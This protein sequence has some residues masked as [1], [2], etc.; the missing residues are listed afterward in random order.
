MEASRK[1]RNT[2]LC[3]KKNLMW[4]YGHLMKLRSRETIYEMSVPSRRSSFSSYSTYN[5]S[6]LCLITPHSGALSEKLAFTVLK[7][8]TVQIQSS[9]LWYLVM[10]PRWVGLL[11]F[12]RNQHSTFRAKCHTEGP[13][14]NKMFIVIDCGPV[15]RSCFSD[16][17]V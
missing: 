11:I 15:G 4:C 13:V 10:R 12:W 2:F 1:R 9:Y 17:W 16:C 7:R 3:Q 14:L 5:P 8:A 6:D